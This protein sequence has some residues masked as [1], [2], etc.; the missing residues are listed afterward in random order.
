MAETVIE[1]QNISKIYKLGQIGS[2]SLRRDLNS[3]WKTSV[4]KQQDPY[5]MTESAQQSNHELWALK[6]VSFDVKQGDA[7]GI[8]GSNGSGKSTLL[9]II[10]RI[11]KPS[12][13]SVRGTGKISSILEVGTGFHPE[14]TGRENIYISAVIPWG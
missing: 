5:F 8:I 6:N 13:G 10:S 14:L 9:K 2:G 3:W 7:L 12:A 1:V 11:V 4:I